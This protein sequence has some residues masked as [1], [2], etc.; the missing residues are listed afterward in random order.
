MTQPKHLPAPFWDILSQFW[1]LSPT[2]LECRPELLEEAEKPL[3][4][5]SV[6]AIAWWRVRGSGLRSLPAAERL[7]DVYYRNAISNMRQEREI[8]RLLGLLRARA[9]EP[10]LIKGWASARLYPNGALRLIGDLDLYIPP[11]KRQAVQELLEIEL[12]D[13][14]DL[15]LQEREYAEVPELSWH[16]LYVRSRLEQLGET[17]VRIPGPEDHLAII[18]LHF[19]RHG[20][21]RPLWLCDVAVA[22][23]SRPTNFD[24]SVCLGTDQRHA[25]W[26]ACAIRLAHELLGADIG[27][28]PI[29]G[30]IGDLP[31]WLMPA[32]LHMWETPTAWAHAQAL[33]GEPMSHYLRHPYGISKAVRARWPSAIQA[34]V[35]VNGPFNDVP[36]LP[37]QIYY[38]LLRALDFPRNVRRAKV[39]Q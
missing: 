2:P 1:R 25:R 10:L 37:F 8:E 29:E 31:R 27:G 22:V 14:G 13:I 38:V 33:Y 16:D 3:V 21:W 26:I 39:R 11:E 6:G 20:A 9:V 32:L 17:M 30:R 35:N 18:C 28:T 12:G 24:W 7:R 15:D 36:R 34:T 23:E 5:M 19:L 4:A